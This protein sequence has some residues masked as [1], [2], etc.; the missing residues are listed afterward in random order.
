MSYALVAPDPWFAIPEAERDTRGVLG[1]DLCVI[2][3][4]EFYIRGSLE[5]PVRPQGETF[6]WSV[7]VSLS[8][9]SFKTALDLW[10]AA[11]RDH[12]PPMFGWLSNAI[13]V[14][15]D[16][17]ALNT[18]VHL[19]NN[20]VRPF[21]RLEPTDHPLAIEQREGITLERIAEIAAVALMH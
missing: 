4:R 7:W 11:Q 15:P 2:D 21:I 20:G 17:R 19:R 13:S 5:L 12:V 10:S 8:E 3:D 14:Y 6:V 1:S 9:R 18:N 16:T